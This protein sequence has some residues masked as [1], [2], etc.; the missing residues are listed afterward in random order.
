MPQEK[1]MSFLDHLEEL[2]NR[3][4]KCLVS[5]MVISIIAFFFSD[6]LIDFIS[7]PL[8][9]VYFM[10]PTEAISVR[11]KIALILGV[12]VSSPVIL[13]HIWQFVVP[14]LLCKEAKVVSTLLFFSTIS[15]LIGGS[16]AFFIVLPYMIQFLLSFGTDKLHPW[17][18]IDDYLSFIGYTTLLFGAVF[19]LPIIAYFLGKIGIISSSTLRKGRRYAVIAI[20]IV[21]A[22][23]TPTPD[24]FNMMLLAVP[25]YLL[26]E[27]SI[28]VLFLQD[29]G[30]RLK[31]T[32]EP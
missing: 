11:M 10:G 20:L 5:V 26:Y 13:Y 30:K 17:I 24:M 32:A 16:F 19:E 29:R 21:S 1:E 15:F 9:G 2:R 25:L 31:K 7:K 28:I 27:I 18:K 8:P 22:L 6:K 14:G 4:I 3:L 23:V 12:I